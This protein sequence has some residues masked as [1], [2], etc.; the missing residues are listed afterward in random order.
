MTEIIKSNSFIVNTQTNIDA[1]APLELSHI[2]INEEYRKKWNIHQHDFVCLSKNGIP[3]R[4]TLYRV[5]GIPADLKKDYFLLLKHVENYYPDNITKITKHK[6]YLD[7]RWCIIDKY[8]NEK[9]VL[10]SFDYINLA[11]GVVYN[12]K[13]KYYNIESGEFYCSSYTSM[14]SDEYLFLD[15]AYDNDKS[16]RGVMK[17]NKK[18]GTWELFKK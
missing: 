2:D 14:S 11:G 3:I 5:G 4:E 9:V 12:V 1:N 8:G 18:D 7:S 6:R 10:S 13:E 15:N 16:K 17:I